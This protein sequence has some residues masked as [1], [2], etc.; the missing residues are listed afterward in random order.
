MCNS[1]TFNKEVETCRQNA[2][3]KHWNMIV[4]TYDEKQKIVLQCFNASENAEVKGLQAY[5]SLKSLL[6]FHFL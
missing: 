4:G 6:Y 1:R 2:Q 5:S 3:K